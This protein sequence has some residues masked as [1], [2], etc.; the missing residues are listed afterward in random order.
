MTTTE[1]EQKLDEVDRL[2]NDP[3]TPL[4]PSRIWRLI[5]DIA[6]HEAARRARRHDQQAEVLPNGAS[7]GRY[8][9][10]PNYRLPVVNAPSP[11]PT[12][13]NVTHAE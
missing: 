6:I 10:P 5:G 2:L 11:R 3:E 1:Y 4:D 12:H 13:N 7:I 9:R 8:Q